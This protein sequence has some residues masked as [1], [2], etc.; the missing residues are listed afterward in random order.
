MTAAA[1]LL[2]LL[3]DLERLMAPPPFPPKEAR[4]LL[5][6]PLSPISLV[7]LQQHIPAHQTTDRGTCQASNSTDLVVWS[8]RRQLV[9]HR[10]QLLELLHLDGPVTNQAPP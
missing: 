7:H 3:R 10:L 1:A 9:G 4:L 2:P 8:V 6:L 5:L